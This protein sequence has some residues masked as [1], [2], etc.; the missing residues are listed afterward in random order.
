MKADT[1]TF[2][3]H[4]KKHRYPYIILAAIVAINVPVLR[5]LIADWIRDDNY[6]HGFFIIPISV[7]LFWRNRNEIT[8]ILLRIKK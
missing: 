1:A 6:S 4:L 2:A 8:R 5:D 7:Y 3:E